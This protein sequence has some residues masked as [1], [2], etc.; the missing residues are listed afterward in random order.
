[1]ISDKDADIINL[2]KALTLLDSQIAKLSVDI[3]NEYVFFLDSA[4]EQT[5]AYES[6]QLTD[7]Q[8]ENTELLGEWA[9]HAGH[10]CAEATQ[11]EGGTL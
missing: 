11:V 7:Q 6:L 1:M 3:D 9:A 10:D 8:R 5:V 2:V 4:P